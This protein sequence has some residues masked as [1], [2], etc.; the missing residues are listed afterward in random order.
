M[1]KLVLWARIV[2]HTPNHFAVVV[3]P[4]PSD[5]AQTIRATDLELADARDLVQATTLRDRLIGN[6]VDDVQMRGDEIVQ[7]KRL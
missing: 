4:A 1:A 2:Q 5:P 6:V 7:V 3:S